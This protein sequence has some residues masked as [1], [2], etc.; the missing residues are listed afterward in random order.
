MLELKSQP[1]EKLKPTH[2]KATCLMGHKFAFRLVRVFLI[3]AT[4]M[5]A[6][7]LFSDSPKLSISSHVSYG[8]SSNLS[9]TSTFL[10]GDRLS[11]EVSGVAFFDNEFFGPRFAFRNGSSHVEL[12]QE[13]D[14]L[15]VEILSSRGNLYTLGPLAKSSDSDV[16]EF[17]LILNEAGSEAIFRVGSNEKTL[18]FVDDTL[19]WNLQGIEWGPQS[20][21]NYVE[22]KWSKK[23][24]KFLP[25]LWIAITSISASLMV[26]LFIGCRAKVIKNHEIS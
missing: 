14:S 4:A 1:I 16:N 21:D 11:G 22:L 8:E 23:E 9:T 17:R 3:F 13:A 26:L 12:F 5:F 2:K 10:A 25:F 24:E 6:M 19:E 7:Y 20:P 15:K 18:N